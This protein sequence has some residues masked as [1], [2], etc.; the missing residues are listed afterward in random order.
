MTCRG[1]RCFSMKSRIQAITLVA[2]M[3]PECMTCIIACF[4]M[5]DVYFVTCLLNVVAC[6]TACTYVRMCA[7]MQV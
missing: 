7:C 6:G 2:D 1:R 3:H 4:R 5:Q